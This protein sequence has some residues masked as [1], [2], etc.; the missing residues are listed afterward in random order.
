MLLTYLVPFIAQ[1]LRDISQLVTE[2]TIADIAAYIQAQLADVLPGDQD[3]LGAGFLDAF[4]TLFQQDRIARFMRSVLDVFTNI[5]YAVL[6]VPFIAFFLLKDGAMIRQSLLRLVPNRY[7]EVT[8][9]IVEK[10][11][12]DL[13]RYF[14][15]LLVQCLSVATVA[16]VLLY[17]VGLNYALA[18]G[19]FTGVANSIPYFGPAMGFLAGTLV[20]IAQTGNLSLIPG[21]LVAMALT[22]MMDNVFFQPLIFSKAARAHPLI[23]LFVVLMGAQL[24]G[25]VGMLVAIPLATIVRVTIVQLLWSLRNYRILR[26]P[27]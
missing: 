4:E 15:G 24:A 16:S 1:Q 17:V 2:D 18:V 19:V 9:A 22:Q 5:F 21:V 13:G 27:R 14:R 10:V 3:Y 12:T 8:L 26:S 20:S 25:I 11:E 23:I 6:I 7:F